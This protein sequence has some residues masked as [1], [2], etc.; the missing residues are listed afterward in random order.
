MGSAQDHNKAQQ[1]AFIYFLFMNE[2]QF[3][4]EL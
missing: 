1:D 4:L 2:Q 3:I